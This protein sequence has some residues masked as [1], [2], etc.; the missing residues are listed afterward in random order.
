[1]N[2]E[3]LPYLSDDLIKYAF[4]VLSMRDTGGIN[5][6]QKSNIKVVSSGSDLSVIVCGDVNQKVIDQL[7]EWPT[8][9]LAVYSSRPKSIKEGLDVSGKLVN[10]YGLM[11]VL[12]SG[13][14][15]SDIYE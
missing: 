13:L 12:L 14:T 3:N 6:S 8:E 1:M 9:K 2:K 7:R 10:T 5:I 15:G 4:E 11:D